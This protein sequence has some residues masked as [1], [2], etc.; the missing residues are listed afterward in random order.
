MGD[1]MNRIAQLEKEINDPEVSPA[2]KEM[3]EQELEV[4]KEIA[5]VRAT[6]DDSASFAFMDN[7][8]P[9]AMENPLTYAENWGKAIHILQKGSGDKKG[10]IDARDWYNIIN[11]MNNIAGA[12]K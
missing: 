1:I 2:R 4:A 10:F 9:G 11:E 5:Q 6:T 7:K 8:L 12:S 3:Y